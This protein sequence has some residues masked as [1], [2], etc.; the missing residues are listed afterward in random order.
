MGVDWHRHCE[1]HGPSVVYVYC[2]HHHDPDTTHVVDNDSACTGGLARQSCK[3]TTGVAHVYIYH[4]GVGIDTDCAREPLCARNQDV[5]T[6]T[7]TES[8]QRGL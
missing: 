5:G 2:I 1:P 8:A 7:V 4:S 3:W 6:N